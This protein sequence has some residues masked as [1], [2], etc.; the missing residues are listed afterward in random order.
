MIIIPNEEA[1]QGGGLWK[2][3]RLGIPTASNFDKIVTSTGAGSSQ[4]KAYMNKLLGEWMTGEPAES[5]KS[6]A[7]EGGTILESEAR[8]FYE[9]QNNVEVH[10][11]SLIYQDERRLIACSPDGLLKNC[12]IETYEKG[13]EAKCPMMHTHIEYLLANKLPT[14][15]KAQVQGSM[16]VAGLNSWDFMSYFPGL[17]PLIINVKRDAR[18]IK[19][20]ADELELFIEEMMEG[21]KELNKLRGYN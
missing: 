12:I 21:R 2:K 19:K 7:M 5:Y 13:Y 10:Q 17:P 9:L 3:L 4:K 16:F 8:L 14:K 18:F 20:L 1:P 11:V 15:Y 6:D